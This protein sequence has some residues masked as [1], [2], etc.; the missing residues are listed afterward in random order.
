MMLLYIGKGEQEIERLIYKK[1][2][3]YMMPLLC[4]DKENRYPWT[5]M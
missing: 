3:L 4:I 1:N 5:F 2:F